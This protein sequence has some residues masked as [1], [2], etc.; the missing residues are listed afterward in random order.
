MNFIVHI[1]PD[2]IEFALKEGKNQII[3]LRAR[4][5]LPRKSNI[6]LHKLMYQR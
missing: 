1:G 5:C 4:C 3:R 2:N 6:F